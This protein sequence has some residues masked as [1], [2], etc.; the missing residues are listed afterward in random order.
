[1]LIMSKNTDLSMPFPGKLRR[2]REIFFS[3]IR[4]KLIVTIIP[5]RIRGRI[6]NLYRGYGE[7]IDTIKIG[8][9]RGSFPVI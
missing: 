5:E 3:D 1:M 2:K 6:R 8:A 7:T 9:A 4:G